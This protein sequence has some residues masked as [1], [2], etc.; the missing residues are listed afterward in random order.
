MSLLVYTVNNTAVQINF[1]KLGDTFGSGYGDSL[2]I[3]GSSGNNCHASLLLT[4]FIGLARYLL[5]EISRESR[6]K[7]SWNIFNCSVMGSKSHDW[8][9][10]IL[11]CT[12][13]KILFLITQGF[14]KVK[15]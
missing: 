7:I 4:Y 13:I 10:Y 6:I 5:D 11:F 14:R 2:S 8:Y 9:K 12:L 1:G 3:G 15:G